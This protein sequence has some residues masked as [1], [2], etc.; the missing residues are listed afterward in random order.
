MIVIDTYKKRKAVYDIFNKVNKEND[1]SNIQGK[2]QLSVGVQPVCKYLDYIKNA[3]ENARSYI[4]ETNKKE[5]KSKFKGNISQSCKVIDDIL[6]TIRSAEHSPNLNEK[7]IDLVSKKLTGIGV[8]TFLFSVGAALDFIPS[9]RILNKWGRNL[10]ILYDNCI[11]VRG[12]VIEFSKRITDYIIALSISANN[13]SNIERKC[14]IL[15]NI[16]NQMA[17][18]VSACGGWIFRD[19]NVDPYNGNY[20]GKYLGKTSW[21]KFDLISSDDN[22]KICLHIGR[23]ISFIY[24]NEILPDTNHDCYSDEFNRYTKNLLTGLQKTLKN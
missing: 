14:K 7:D 8:S 1:M 13:Q 3:L 11:N 5:W 2:I 17:G 19:C 10:P 21:C 6:I 20:D 12:E 15:K 9:I 23:I 16:F 4:V 18:C 24:K 22:R